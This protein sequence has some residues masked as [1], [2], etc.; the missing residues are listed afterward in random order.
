MPDSAIAI[1]ISSDI[2][3]PHFLLAQSIPLHEV[4]DILGHSS[5]S[6]T[7]DVYGHMTA[8]RRRAAAD[9][10]DRILTTNE[11]L[12]NPSTDIRRRPS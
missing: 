5:V 10:M 3:R 2:R 7:K 11:Y 1:L 12:D 4:S 8:E 9:A 6:V